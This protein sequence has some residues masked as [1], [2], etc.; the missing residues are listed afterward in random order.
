M[1][2]DEEGQQIALSENEVMEGLTEEL[3][4][5][6]EEEREDLPS[7]YTKRTAKSTPLKRNTKIK[8]IEKRGKFE[9]LW[10]YQGK[11]RTTRYSAAEE[12]KFFTAG[13]LPKSVEW[14]H[15][16]EGEQDKGGENR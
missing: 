5:E 12:G 10:A 2:G 13:D 1:Q 7:G 16:P 9:D 15:F 6:G 3:G 11:N 8:I 14:G 4:A